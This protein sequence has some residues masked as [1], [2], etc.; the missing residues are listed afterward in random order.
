MGI[1]RQGGREREKEVCGG[2]LSSL[3]EGD[4]ILTKIEKGYDTQKRQFC[5]NPAW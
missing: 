1:R 3:G 2:F 4:K 5:V